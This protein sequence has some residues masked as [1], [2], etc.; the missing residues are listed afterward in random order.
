MDEKSLSDLLSQLIPDGSEAEPGKGEAQLD[1]QKGSMEEILKAVAGQSGGSAESAVNEFLNGEGELFE[2]TRTALATDR[3]S[4][5]SEVAAF[6]K[7]KLKLSSFAAKLIAMMVV[8]LFP[9]ITD[10][11]GDEA[12]PKKKPRRKKRKTSSS[13]KTETSS[14]KKPKKKTT[15][16][17]KTSS[18]KPAVKKK[19]AAKTSKKKTTPKKKTQ[20]KTRTSSV[21]DAPQNLLNI[22]DSK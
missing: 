17:P 15:A 22:T 11:T 16:R 4:A 10:L 3:K 9:S 20:K 2:T 1:E 5:E 13:A 21:S 12:P 18:S 14:K 6:L 7:T 19:P 8:K